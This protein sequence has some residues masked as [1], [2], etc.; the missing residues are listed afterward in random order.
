MTGKFSDDLTGNTVSF[1]G[2]ALVSGGDDDGFVAKF[3]AAGVHQWSIRFGGT[4]FPDIGNGIATD[5]TSVYVVG[6]ATNI[7]TIGTSATTYNTIGGGTDGLVMKLNATTG[8][9]D[10]VTRF[11]GAQA[12]EGQAI[13]IDGPGN[14]YISG[15][16]RTRTTNATATFGSFTRTVQGNIATYTSDLFLAKLN[17]SGVFQWVSTGGIG[18][19]NDN[20]NGSGIC[21][22]PALNE[23]VVTGSFRWATGGT[24]ATYTTT[25]PASSVSLIGSSATVQEDF[26]LL[27]VNANTGEFMSGSAAGTASGNEAGLGI[28]YDPFSGNV[29]FAGYFSSSSVTFPGLAANN[30]ASAGRDNI[31][32]GGYNPN[33]NAYIWV[34]DVDNSTPASAADVARCITANGAG[35][36]IIAGNFRNTVTFPSAL[37]LS[38]SGAQADIFAARINVLTGNTEYVKLGAGNSAA[39]DDIAYGIASATDGNIWIT[40][41]YT[42]SL[43]LAPLAALN[44]VGNKEDILLARY[45]DIP[46]LNSSPSNV[47]A[48]AGQPASFA[49]GAA[50]AGTLTYS[51]QEA[52][53]SIFTTGL[54][55]LSNTGVYSGTNTATLTISDVSGLNNRF[56]R[57]IISN[58]NGSVTSAGAT[59]SVNPTVTLSSGAT[60]TQAVNTNGNMYFAAGCALLAKI[61]PAGANPITGSVTTQV[62]V[63]SSVPAHG[64]EPFVQRHYQITPGTNPA[65]ATAAVTLYFSQAEFTDFNAAPGSLLNLPA[66]AADN[67]GKSNLR[68]G[69]YPGSS[70]NG[71]GLPSSY[72]T[73]EVVIDPPDANIVFNAT[74][75]RWEVTF[76]VVGF[77]GFVLQSNPGV[78][79]VKLV[80]FGAQLVGDDVKLKWQTASEVD[81]DHFEVERSFNGKEFTAIGQRVANNGNNTTDY[82]LIDIAAALQGSSKLFYRLK[83]ISISGKMEYSKTVIIL[84]DKKGVFVTGILP[85][86]FVNEINIGIDA[87]RVGKINVS[88]VDMTGRVLHRREIRVLKGFSTQTVDKLGQLGR[89]VY[90][91]VI[92]YEGT[93][94]TYKVIK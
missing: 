27:E 22:V 17:S 2:T 53:N 31:L 30:N 63:E 44:S 40:G 1:G 28:T 61:I 8:A 83:T 14:I 47:S 5:G 6:T 37:V 48:C 46:V 4:G 81:N 23:V 64:N 13:C 18:S 72:S 38:A 15:I 41:Q 85:N 68:I 35:A 45:G 20:I 67:A 32:Y 77:S 87:P 89:G 91:L 86:P 33:T 50:G 70:N 58:G 26:C 94:S 16:F 21:Y 59:L 49:V 51:W 92:E 34:R 10:W 78:L 71:T 29:F 90:T 57:S 54:I 9:L 74:F 11:G 52:T 93:I 75:N 3:N 55:T 66:N 82:E 19:G 39:A 62:W 25:T 76:D 65:N 69:K 80:S 7:I 73:T 12:D 88:L 84:L 79:P 60:I 42:T 43:T 24:T 36:V 56:Y